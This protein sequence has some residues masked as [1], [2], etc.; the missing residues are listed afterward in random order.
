MKKLFLWAALAVGLS[1]CGS[2][3]ATDDHQGHDHSTE[4]AVTTTTASG[5]VDPVCNMAKGDNWTEFVVAGTDTTWFC[6]PH[7]KEAYEA[8]PDKYKL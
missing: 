2:N 5:P 4:P 8:N 1:A 3:E 7:C 6:S